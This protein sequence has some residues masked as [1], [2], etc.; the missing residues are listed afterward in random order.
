MCRT[1]L[2]KLNSAVCNVE[3]SDKFGQWMTEHGTSYIHL[4][5]LLQ[6]LYNMTHSNPF[7]PFGMQEFNDGTMIRE[8]L[9]NLIELYIATNRSICSC[10]NLERL[11]F[12][13]EELEI[14]YL[15]I[16]INGDVDQ[17]A[18]PLVLTRRSDLRQLFKTHVVRSAMT[19]IK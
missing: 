13:I 11:L 7:V 12:I 17:V 15:P 5:L 3:I 6:L 19:Q 18:T 1:C 8:G 10:T 2:I 14:T 16:D 9:K 4:P